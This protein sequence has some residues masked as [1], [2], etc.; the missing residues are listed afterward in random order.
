[1]TSDDGVVIVEVQQTSTK[2]A[3]QPSS[4]SSA[5][6]KTKKIPDGSLSSSK[7]QVD[8]S[9]S[10]KKSSRT[11]PVR[12]PPDTRVASIKKN[13]LQGYERKF[14]VVSLVY[15]EVIQTFTYKPSGKT[16]QI[17]LVPFWHA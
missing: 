10:S 8:G 12:I 15:P 3:A 6:K 5:A 11:K 13:K 2:W 7:K 1:M 16:I 14:P 17:V 4:S 9:S